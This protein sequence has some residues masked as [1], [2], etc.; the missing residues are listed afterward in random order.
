M[1]W[2]EAMRAKALATRS[3]RRQKKKNEQM[4]AVVEDQHDKPWTTVIEAYDWEDAPL[5]EAQTKAAEMK[6]EYDRVAAIIVRRQNPANAAWT[7]WTEENK[8]NPEVEIPKSV[9]SQCLRRG[10]DGKWK[11]RDDGRFVQVDGI[12]T[13]KSAFCCNV[14]CFSVYQK[15]KV[16]PPVRA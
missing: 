13:L 9:K 12:R 11:F 6:R 7:C 14:Y 2:T 16:R 1:A 5:H 10:P 4:L 8:K 3:E 15:Y